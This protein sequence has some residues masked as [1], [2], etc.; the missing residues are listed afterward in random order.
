MILLE[1]SVYGRFLNLD[2]CRIVL[3]FTL[4]RFCK[5]LPY[6][7]I[8]SGNEENSYIISTLCKSVSS[9]I[10]NKFLHS[11]KSSFFLIDKKAQLHKV[12]FNLTIFPQPYLRIES[13]IF[14]LRLVSALAL[15]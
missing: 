14:Q 12:K 11:T 6:D 2:H 1:G 15:L 5:S 9:F 10:E 4:H 13:A 7:K 3:Y 8:V